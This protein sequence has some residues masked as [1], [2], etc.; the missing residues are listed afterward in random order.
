MP[1]D[2]LE[3]R[4]GTAVPRRRRRRRSKADILLLCLIAVFALG[5]AVSGGMLLHY[6]LENR[7]AQSAFSEL[8]TLVPTPAAP[9]P[10]AP[11][12]DAGEPAARDNTERFAQLLAKNG[13]FAGWLTIEGTKV[14]YPVMYRPK[15]EDYYLRRDF[16]GGYSTSGVPYLEERCTFGADGCSNNL[17]VYGHNMKSGTMFNALLGYARQEFYEAHKTI[18]FDTLY[19]NAEYEVFAAFALDVADNAFPYDTMT[20]LDEDGFD[21]YI[22]EV[23]RRSYLVTGIVPQYGDRLLTLS[24]CEYAHTDGRFL[25][26]ARQIT[27]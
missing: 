23:I 7:A 6:H 24:T 16:E 22:N 15:N 21:R 10:A 18:V 11:A 17:I 2:A 14:D 27:A 4:R 26:L 19:E 8:K 9:A 5:L 3:A 13:D 12:D 1:R 25:V 20:D